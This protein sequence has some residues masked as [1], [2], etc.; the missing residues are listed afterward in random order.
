MADITV[1]LTGLPRREQ[2]RPAV[3]AVRAQQEIL[4]PAEN[5]VAVQEDLALTAKMVG[6]S[7]VIQ[8]AGSSCLCGSRKDKQMGLL[9]FTESQSF[10]PANYGITNKTI[11]TAIAVGGGA[12]GENNSSGNIGGAAGCG[13]KAYPDSSGYGGGGG[14]GGGG[15]G[16]G[17]GGAGGYGDAKYALGGNGGGA[18]EV[19]TKNITFSDP[20]ESISITIAGRA[21]AATAGEPTSIGSLVIAKGGERNGGGKAYGG[22]YTDEY[23]TG[24]GGG[25][26][27]YQ[28]GAW[29]NNHT[30]GGDGGS[31]DSNAGSGNGSGG[32]GGAGRSNSKSGAGG[33]YGGGAGG[34]G[35]GNGKDG[36]CHAGKA[37]QGVVVL[38]W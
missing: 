11:V 5:L 19:I 10:M 17:G 22:E 36:Y 7:W 8:V 35:G 25:A 24:G 2:G 37:G 31:R 38:F 12:G 34:G 26:G 33:A 13:G 29:F 28:L 14:G 21:A 23:G 18:G 15:F 30:D 3:V 1:L 6:A 16:A 32:G 4:L 20:S 9:V 27:G